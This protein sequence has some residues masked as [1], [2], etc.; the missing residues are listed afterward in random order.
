MPEPVNPL[1]EWAVFVYLAG[2]V[3]EAQMHTAAIRHLVQMA[4]VGSSQKVYLAAQIYL[5]GMMPRRYI[6]PEAPQEPGSLTIVPDPSQPNVNSA[7][8]RSILDFIQWAVEKCPA[9][10]TMVV[11][12]GHG[13]G[14]DDYTPPK[15]HMRS[16]G[17]GI[18]ALR[19]VAPPV[20]NI[21]LTNKILQ[22]EDLSDIDMMF[23]D[24]IYDWAA[25]EVIPNTQVGQA[26]RRSVQSLPDQVKPAILGFDSCEMAM[27]EVWCEM[28]DCATIGISSQAPIPYQGWPYG[29][30]VKRLLQDPEASPERVAQTI[31]DTFVESYIR[32]QNAYV[33]LSAVNLSAIDSLTAGVKPLADALTAVVRNPQAQNAIFEARNYCPIYDPDGFIDLGCF[34]KFLKITMPNSPV[35]AACDPALDALTRFVVT[36]DYSP[37]NPKKKVSQSTGLSVWFPEWI[38]NPSVRYPEKD[39]S[40]AYLTKGYPDTQFAQA[41]GWDRFLVGLR[42]AI[43]NAL[44]LK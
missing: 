32:D 27:A 35:S 10:N 25:G 41:T 13:Y 29:T 38:Q 2:N 14:I 42:N 8:P 44:E 20:K 12:W 22:M 6:L 40:I 26:I 11:L 1:K 16:A 5:P 43:G 30:V 15:A 31:I 3:P 18:G 34:C 4:R 19:M 33:T 36:S 21:A 9:K 39:K 37:Q 28:V 17:Q 24:F 7:D 23:D